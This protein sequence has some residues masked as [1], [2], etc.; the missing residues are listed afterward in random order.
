[1]SNKKTCLYARVSTQDQASGLESKVRSLND[2]CRMN[3]ITHYEIFAD[4]GGG[5]GLE[6]YH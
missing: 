5:G 6:V 1:M 3:N 2:Y 4:E